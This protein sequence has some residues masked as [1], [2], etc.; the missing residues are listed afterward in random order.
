MVLG[1]VIGGVVVFV[2][3]LVTASQFKKTGKV[4]F[5]N[6]CHEMGV[7]YGTWKRGSHGLIRLGAMRAK[8]VDC[9]LP[10]DG[11]IHYIRVKV[12]YGVNDYSL[13]LRA[14]KPANSIGLIIGRRSL[15]YIRPMN[16]GVRAVIKRS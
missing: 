16:L 8:C 15:T 13:T 4:A 10:Q 12:F 9:L 1:I 6:S 2:F 3:S 11:I 14:G 7:F 5:C